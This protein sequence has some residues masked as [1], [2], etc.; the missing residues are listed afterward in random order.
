VRD[1]CRARITSR[2]VRT[3]GQPGCRDLADADQTIVLVENLA[4][5]LTLAQRAYSIN[6]SH[7]T[8]LSGQPATAVAEL[9]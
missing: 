7:V 6:N 2:P 4:A 3:D 8:G 5:A 1:A 9:A